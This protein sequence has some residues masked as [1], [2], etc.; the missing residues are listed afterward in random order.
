[1]SDDECSE[2][3][4]RRYAPRTLDSRLDSLSESE[5]QVRNPRSEG[6][7]GTRPD[8]IVDAVSSSLSRASAITV[9]TQLATVTL[10]GI[11]TVN[12]EDYVYS[13]QVETDREQSI[14]LFDVE[15]RSD[16]PLK[17]QSARTHFIGDDDYTYSSSRLSLKPDVLGPGCYTR[18]VE[19]PSGK[20]GRIVTLVEQLPSGVEIAEVIHTISVRGRSSGQDRFVFRLS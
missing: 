4:R 5:K 17:W 13:H 15:N 12:I 1:M 9:E 3:D 20:R 16:R 7:A 14:A 2:D 18:Q 19:I 8:S 11:P 6:G 10:V